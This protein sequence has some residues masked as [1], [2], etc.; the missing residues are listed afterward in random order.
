MTERISV[1]DLVQ[2]VRG[3]QCTVERFCGLIFVVAEIVQ[4]RGGGWHCPHCNLD[5]AGPNEPA[6]GMY[7]GARN[8]VPLSYLKRIPPLSELESEQRKE[9]VGA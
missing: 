5:S 2:V 3:H 1:G 6:A 7:V 4:P 8:H 9:E